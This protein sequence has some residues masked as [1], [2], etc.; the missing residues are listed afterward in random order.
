MFKGNQFLLIG[1]FSD[2]RHQEIKRLIVQNGGSCVVNCSMNTN[3]II[4]PNK[5]KP[6]NC[7]EKMKQ[8]YLNNNQLLHAKRKGKLILHLSFLLDSI[9]Q[10]RVVPYNDHLVELFH[11]DKV[12]HNNNMDNNFE[13]ED[14]KTRIYGHDDD[15]KTSCDFL[16]FLNE[17]IM[18]QNSSSENET[19]SK[20]NRS[21]TFSEVVPSCLS[22][23]VTLETHDKRVFYHNI[24]TGNS[25][26]N[27]PNSF[28]SR[29]IITNGKEEILRNKKRFNDYNYFI[30]S[31]YQ[32]FIEKKKNNESKSSSSLEELFPIKDLLKE[33]DEK[34]GG[35]RL[36]EKKDDEEENRL[37]GTKR[38][39]EE[40]D[41][42]LE[43]S[44]QEEQGNGQ[45]PPTKK[46]K[47]S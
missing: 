46:M 14:F 1:K 19:E 31:K 26:W 33:Y 6:G 41:H 44:K 25:Q 23:W 5:L 13:E 47:L 35:R 29:K 32:E 24:V 9:E 2:Y 39:R 18:N 38:K 45:Q 20:K 10:K 22:Y 12:N 36:K 17:S 3:F 8:K 15:E 7:D 16:K 27:Q 4:L 42:S 11:D 37:S 30:S 28:D 34:I 43:Q 40:E 21:F